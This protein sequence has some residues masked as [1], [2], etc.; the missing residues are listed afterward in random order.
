M[1][2]IQH[3]RLLSYKDDVHFTITADVIIDAMN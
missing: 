1:E 2:K 3:E